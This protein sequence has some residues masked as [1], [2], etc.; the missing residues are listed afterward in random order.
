MSNKVTKSLYIPVYI[1]GAL[2][3]IRKYPNPQDLIDLYDNYKKSYKIWDRDEDAFYHY[4]AALFSAFY[5]NKDDLKARYGM[6]RKKCFVFADSGGYQLITGKA[7]EGKWTPE[8]ALRWAEANASVTPILDFPSR[9]KLKSFQ[10]ALDFSEKSARWAQDNRDTSSPLRILN[11]LSGSRMA[12]MEDWY[13]VMGEFKFEGWAHGGSEGHLISY[14]EAILFLM[15]K[16][17]YTP[18]MDKPMFHHIFGVT[19]PQAMVYVAYIQ[20]LLNEMSIPVTITYD[21]S[22]ASMASGMGK[23]FSNVSLNGVTSFSLSK[24]NPELIKRFDQYSELGTGCDCPVCQSIT[25]L[26]DMLRKEC[27]TSNQYLLT[28]LHNVYLQVRFKRSMENMIYLGNQEFYDVS[29]PSKVS[30]SF[31]LLK[32]AFESP[33]KYIHTLFNDFSRYGHSYVK[34]KATKV[35]VTSF[36]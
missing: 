23:W 10:E 21:S 19:N 25:N 24:N 31:R 33:E 36:F 13:K 15:N 17:V 16:G 2:T 35:S 4:P 11:V 1:G 3:T 14:V 7:K 5:N 8:I 12:Q 32:R 34:E 29:F 20:K 6:D 26:G 27:Y 22:S 28:W 9:S 30:N 18:D